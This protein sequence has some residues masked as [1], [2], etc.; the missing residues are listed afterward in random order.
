MASSIVE[1][2]ED[3]LQYALSIQSGPNN[4]STFLSVLHA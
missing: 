3:D 2:D 1:T 4:I